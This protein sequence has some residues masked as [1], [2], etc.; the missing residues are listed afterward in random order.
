MN[1]PNKNILKEFNINKI[2]GKIKVDKK[3]LIIILIGL[4]G[5]ILVIFS[6]LSSVSID[7]NDEVNYDVQLSDCAE[8]EEKLKNI[9]ENING[10]GE[11]VVYITYDCTSETIYATDTDEKKSSDEIH[12][13]KEYIVTDN[14]MAIALKTVYPEVRGVAVVCRGGADPV[15]KEKIYSAVMALFGISMNRIS[16]SDMN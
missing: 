9:I 8:T 3:S 13:K 6:D 4:I 7:D 11:T 16:I 15:V 12:T 10:A 1:L 14:D 2:A 5:V